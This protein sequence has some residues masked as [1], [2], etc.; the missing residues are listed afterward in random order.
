MFSRAVES[1][2]VESSIA[3]SYCASAREGEAHLVELVRQGRAIELRDHVALL[4]DRPFRHD[5]LDLHLPRACL[6]RA[7]G[8]GDLDELPR[9]QLAGG[10]HG[11]GN[12]PRLTRATRELS[13]PAG[14][15]RQEPGAGTR[16]ATPIPIS[17]LRVGRKARSVA[18]DGR[19]SERMV[20]LKRG[21]PRLDTIQPFF[22]PRQMGL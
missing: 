16:I 15:A 9:P 3:C 8:R 19:E 5:G 18:S 22:V 12:G 13:G 6:L 14:P 10:G 7:G 4:D 11:D 2:S 1:V 17:C 21:N 20:Y